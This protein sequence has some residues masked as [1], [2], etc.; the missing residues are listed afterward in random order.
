MMIVL[1]RRVGNAGK[2]RNDRSRVDFRQASAKEHSSF[3]QNLNVRLRRARGAC[4]AR[5]GSYVIDTGNEYEWTT[6]RRTRTGTYAEYRSARVLY[7]LEYEVLW[8]RHTDRATQRSNHHPILN[9]DIG[10]RSEGTSGVFSFRI[11]LANQ[12]WPFSSPAVASFTGI[13]P[14]DAD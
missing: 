11:A 5:D 4:P 7:V 10:H 12:K 9:L 8:D 13:C 1:V 3:G 2:S 6:A 14:Q